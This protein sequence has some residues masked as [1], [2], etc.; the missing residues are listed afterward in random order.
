MWS[1]KDCVAMRLFQF[2]FSLISMNYSL[3]KKE[4][5]LAGPSHIVKES[6]K[7]ILA[8]PLYLDLHQN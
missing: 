6:D 3:R 1:Q 4:N 5:L 8:L 2:F 7:Q